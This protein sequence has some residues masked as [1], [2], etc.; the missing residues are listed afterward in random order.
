MERATIFVIMVLLAVAVYPATCFAYIDPNAG[1]WLFQL[2]F[3]VVVAIG[4]MWLICKSLVIKF[5]H[6]VLRYNR[7]LAFQSQDVA[8][9]VSYLRVV[10]V[11]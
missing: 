11:G 6:K 9:D 5:V 4:A 7:D 8:V 3:P 2:L 10:G 1:G